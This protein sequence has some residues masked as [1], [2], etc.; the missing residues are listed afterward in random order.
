MQKEIYNR[1][2]R[3]A[4]YSKCNYFQCVLNLSQKLLMQHNSYL[5]SCSIIYESTPHHLHLS[6]STQSVKISEMNSSWLNK[7]MNV[8]ET[9]NI[10]NLYI[11]NMHCSIHLRTSVRNWKKQLFDYFDKHEKLFE[12]ENR[13]AYYFLKQFTPLSHC[14]QMKTERKKSKLKD[15]I[16][17]ECISLIWWKFLR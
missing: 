16:Q 12:H 5:V 8:P 10:D 1:D 6:L 13:I 17:F 9:Q 14:F 11:I 7:H 2:I 15:K 3:H 4:L